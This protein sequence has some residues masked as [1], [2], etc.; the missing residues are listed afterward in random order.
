MGLLSCASRPSDLPS[1]K[2][3]ILDLNKEHAA[4]VLESQRDRAKLASYEKESERFQRDRDAWEKLRI[5]QQTALQQ[6]AGLISLVTERCSLLANDVLTVEQSEGFAVNT[7]TVGSLAR[8][9]SGQPLAVEI[10]VSAY[11]PSENPQAAARKEGQEDLP[12]QQPDDDEPLG[13]K[14]VTLLR[15][16]RPKAGEA[17]AAHEQAGDAAAEATLH[18]ALARIEAGG[19]HVAQQ[20]RDASARCEAQAAE[21]TALKVWAVRE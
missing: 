20:L 16:G 17:P 19:R 21:K 15:L 6:Q 10:M 7:G 9:R 14:G 13:P 2:Q 5:D 3:L 18:A 12:P 11:E 1:K 8:G 4:L